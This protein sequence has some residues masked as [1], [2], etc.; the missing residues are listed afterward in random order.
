[1]T[2]AI[3]GMRGS[4]GLLNSVSQAAAVVGAQMVAA[5]NREVS[6]PAQTVQTEDACQAP[7]NGAPSP[8]Y[9]ES[10]SL[11]DENMDRALHVDTPL[12]KWSTTLATQAQAYADT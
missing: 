2:V 9:V 5:L 6:S 3:A 10:A 1:M 11:P 4:S 8:A 12:L 7:P